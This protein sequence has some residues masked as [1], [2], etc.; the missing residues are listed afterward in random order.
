MSSGKGQKSHICYAAFLRLKARNFLQY[1]V[2]RSSSLVCKNLDKSSVEAKKFFFSRLELALTTS[3]HC[4][5]SHGQIIRVRVS[6]HKL[7]WETL[8][9]PKLAWIKLGFSGTAL[10]H[11]LCYFLCALAII[12]PLSQYNQGFCQLFLMRLG[13]ALLFK[14]PSSFSLCVVCVLNEVWRFSFW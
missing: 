13:H 11:L 4:L 2:V 12:Y 14:Y 3:L 10:E 1:Q 8:P 7:S 5:S 6:G 9:F